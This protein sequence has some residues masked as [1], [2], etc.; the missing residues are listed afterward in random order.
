[1][2]YEMLVE[3][4]RQMAQKEKNLGNLDAEAAL[5]NDMEKLQ[6]WMD[7]GQAGP[8]PIDLGKYDLGKPAA[9]PEAA[10]VEQVAPPLKTAARIKTT[11]GTMGKPAPRPSKTRTEAPTSKKTMKKVEAESAVQLL[12]TKVVAA[13]E[14]AAIAEEVESPEQAVLRGQLDQARQYFDKK[15]LREAVALATQVENRSQDSALKETAGHLLTQARRQL[16]AAVKKALA[17]GDAASNAG[18]TELARKH[19]Q[20]ARELDPDNK[21]VKR[22]L[23]ELD[24]VLVTQISEAKIQA[25]RAGLRER[26]DIKRLGEAVYEAEA[27]YGEGKLTAEFDALLPEARKFYD[28]T[29]KEQ[30]EITTAMRFGDLAARSQ[31][32]KDITDLVATGQKFIFDVTTNTEKP[33][34]DLL[35][36]ANK[37]LE[38]AS[39]DTA[40]Y[41]LDLANKQLPAHP[42]YARKRL[43]AALEQ[44]F[45][46]H[47]KRKLQ[48][49]LSEVEALIQL[50]E[51]T[52]ELL[53]QDN[54][55][56]E[57][58][59]LALETYKTFPLSPGHD[60]QISQARQM[61][62]ASLTAR[63]HDLCQQ[64]E[65]SLRMGEYQNARKKT[66][67]TEKL[68]AAWPEEQKPA[69]LKSLLDGV[70]E[71]RQRIDAT[72][73]MWNEYSKLANTIREQV[74]DPARRAAA[75]DLFREVSTDK[76]FKAFPDLKV[77]TSEIDN[78]K[79]VGEQLTDAQSAHTEG[80]WSRVYE[81]ADKVIKSA[82][83]GQLADKF[84]ELH[85]E[86]S[87]ELAISRAK[88]LLDDDDVPEA[89]NILSAV[90]NKERGTPRE[91]VLRQRLEHELK[92]IAQCITD[93]APMQS[94]FE[95]ASDLVGLRDS[96]L[97]KAYANP[98]YALRQARINVDGQATNSEMRD[99]INSLKTDPN[100]P[101]PL[102]QE[103]SARAGEALKAELGKKGFAERLEAMHLFRYVG[104][105]AQERQPGW[106]EFRPSLRT[107]EARRAER[108][109]SESLRSD[110]L[111]ALKKAYTSRREKMLDDDTLRDMAERARGM[112]DAGLL[113]TDEDKVAGRWLEIEWGKRQAQVGEGRGDWNEVVSI[114]KR[115]LDLYGTPE[116]RNGWRRAR[117]QQ[118]IEQA[119]D[120]VYNHHQGEDALAVLRKVQAEAGVGSACELHLALADT[121]AVLGNFDSAFGCLAEAGQFSPQKAVQTAVLKKRKELEREKLIQQA[122]ADAQSKKDNSPHE[123]LR[124]LQNALGTPIAKDSRR[125]CQL[126]DKIFTK[127]SE[128]LLKTAK[129]EQAI[130]SDEG[131]IKAVV[132]LVD[133]QG[134]EELAGVPANRRRSIG[135]LGRL[136]SGLT[137][138]AESVIRSAQDFD[139]SSMMLEQAILRAGALSSRLQTFDSVIPLFSAELE[140]VKERLVKRR[141]DVSR[142]LDNLQALKKL[143]DEALKASLWEEALQMGDFQ[144]LEKYARQYSQ[145]ELSDMQEVHTFE[146]RLAEWKE[147]RGVMVKEIKEI[148]D[149]FVKEEAFEDIL[150]RLRRLTGMPGLRANGQPWQSLQQRDYDEI[151]HFMSG[152][153]RIHDLYEE[154]LAGW[155]AVEAASVMRQKELELWQEWDKSC[156]L[157]MDDMYNAVKAILHYT[158]VLPP[159]SELMTIVPDDLRML[160][161]AESKPDA[162]VPPIRL[163]N[164]DWNK[165]AAAAQAAI[166]ALIVVPK[167]G[168][169]PVLIHSQKA[170]S[171]QAEGKRRLRI[172]E[173]WLR[174]AQKQ[175]AV[176]DD[177]LKEQGF[178]SAQEFK[179]AVDQQDWDRLERL[180]A[181]AR[182]AGTLDLQEQKQMTVYS[183]V[184]EEARRQE[185]RQH[186]KKRLFNLG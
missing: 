146:K 111:E 180:L 163:K 11:K 185:A 94:L 50:Q 122:I 130:G 21:D 62:L 137:S 174:E 49:K 98:N 112:R 52:G 143:L 32:V 173:I 85:A 35:Q 133:L 166:D 58:F 38:G 29:R 158:R 100:G 176:L 149:K 70:Q 168:D 23:L 81:I 160:G 69:E 134:L 63:I 36:E 45:S 142:S 33:S 125:L 129:E 46:E 95:R 141:G 172:A 42:K 164:R 43:T 83:A 55:A 28:E 155:E 15:Q 107:A 96:L 157:G 68:A 17:E 37:L 18:K 72:E 40:Q 162:E 25:L 4:L 136:R 161:I 60:A 119:R 124:I 26:K 115:L 51:K 153:L 6:A 59:R 82:K 150:T 3:K 97:F 131:K 90:L 118:A 165:I 144:T 79:G 34:F 159:T 140:M 169:A 75:L 116:V 120:L 113:E 74:L 12:E 87:I 66:A 93:N 99:L 167:D 76:R 175:I 19:F 135:E 5:I 182:A 184:L 57:I 139:P 16:T 71:I 8:C 151:R 48:E 80:D 128:S 54:G 178:P 64:A 138:V 106:L 22:A 2:D 44:P 31:A 114:W 152:Q 132:A 121:H 183:Q 47:Y 126:Q 108:L 67:E 179:E 27:L 9:T 92:K 39:E 156:V 78:Y 30:G 104:G 181:R 127:A 1:M 101:D 145:L 105:N 65:L 77:L 86:A 61:A 154:E 24:G 110:I 171:L 91:A 109:V 53:P 41:E 14:L 102:A 186:K 84:N 117:I 148:K 73:N 10:P 7:G 103:L 13:E 88:S 177:L 89:N 56:V 170:K 20:T 147:I 123:A